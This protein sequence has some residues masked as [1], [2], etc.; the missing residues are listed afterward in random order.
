M[1]ETLKERNNDSGQETE[2]KKD[3]ERDRRIKQSTIKRKEKRDKT[4]YRRI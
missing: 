1:T 3:E 4:R 2:R